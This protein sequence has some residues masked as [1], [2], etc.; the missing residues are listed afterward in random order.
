MTDIEAIM[1]LAP[2]LEPGAKCPPQFHLWSDSKGLWH[3]KVTM[4]KYYVQADDHKTPEGALK[5]LR[6]Q[7]TALN[8][9]FIKRM[10]E[11]VM[12]WTGAQTSLRL[13]K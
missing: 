13:V 10:T 2:S 11:T 6:T 4:D 7:L 3:T 8:Q 5:D 9:S 12:R 1:D